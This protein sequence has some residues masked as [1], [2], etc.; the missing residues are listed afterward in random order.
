MLKSNIPIHIQMAIPK[1]SNNFETG[2]T[3]ELSPQGSE[4]SVPDGLAPPD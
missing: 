1:Q 3:P 4:T 2:K